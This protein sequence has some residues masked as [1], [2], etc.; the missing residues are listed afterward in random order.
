MLVLEKQT[1][2]IK[3]FVTGRDALVILPTGSGKSLNIN[4]LVEYF[5]TWSSITDWSGQT[6]TTNCSA[7]NYDGGRA[8]LCA[9]NVK[10]IG[11]SRIAEQLATA[12]WQNNQ[13]ISPSHELSVSIGLLLS[14]P[15]VLKSWHY[16]TNSC[17]DRCLW[18]IRVECRYKTTATTTSIRHVERVFTAKEHRIVPKTVV[19]YKRHTVDTFWPA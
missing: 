11:K 5:L 17:V 10:C 6:A 18:E 15:A 8:S 4:T 13:H 2:A 7:D 16:F 1:S 3:A 14:R 19:K 9:Q 12:R